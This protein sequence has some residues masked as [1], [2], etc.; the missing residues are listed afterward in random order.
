MYTI[1]EMNDTNRS[2]VKDLF[3]EEWEDDFMVTRGN[4][5]KF[6]DLKGYVAVEFG[7]ILGFITY[8]EYENETEITS[9]N[10]YREKNGIG[11]ALLKTVINVSVQ[12]DVDR[13]FLITTNDNHY[14]MK[15]YQRIGFSMCNL[16]VG[17]VNETRKIKD[18][19]LYND[20][21]MVEHEIELEMRF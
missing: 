5:I 17:A 14:A 4:V 11:N 16:Y 12:R 3:I 10:S 6:D 1:I 18:I 2:D 20:F 8:N 7:E 13:V 15:Y 9:L 19:P 21:I